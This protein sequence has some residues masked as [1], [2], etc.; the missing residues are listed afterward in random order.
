MESN[1]Q[2]VRSDVSSTAS[3]SS[4][5][6]SWLQSLRSHMESLDSPLVPPPSVDSGE[7][8][9]CLDGLYTA[10]S[11]LESQIASSSQRASDAAQSF[12]AFQSSLRQA[13][14]PLA[15][16]FD[17]SAACVDQLRSLLQ[18]L[19]QQATACESL[20]IELQAREQAVQEKQQMLQKERE[21]NA[22]SLE[23]A[24]RRCEA[25]KSEVRDLLRK[26]Q[27][28]EE[29]IEAM[30]DERTQWEER[31]K[32]LEEQLAEEKKKAENAEIL[33]T[34]LREKIT[35]LENETESMAIQIATY[36]GENDELLTDRLQWKKEKGQM[37]QLQ[38]LLNAK[39]Q[40]KN[41][42]RETLEELTAQHSQLEE[43]LRH[44]SI[45]YK[46]AQEDLDYAQLC[47]KNLQ[48]SLAVYT[49][50]NQV[51]ALETKD[52]TPTENNEKEKGEGEEPSEPSEPSSDLLSDNNAAQK[53]ADPKSP[54]EPCKE[55]ATNKLLVESLQGRIATMDAELMKLRRRI[56]EEVS[57]EGNV[58]G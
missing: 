28:D 33:N 3:V 55:C 32:R 29:R 10:Q 43:E 30:Q 56:M 15:L 21:R 19:Q 7:L 41:A 20:R 11:S 13:L 8:Y 37:D 52:E 39:E 18:S 35:S 48:A 49:R 14:E 38:A 34:Q 53:E 27:Q 47:V 25:L 50:Q 31:V 51:P 5:A 40:E 57:L 4:D 26:E 46:N 6:L 58:D 45:E 54:I 16:S 22:L 9:V 2:Q 24:E 36:K 12:A 23:N 17:G 1:L 42:L 44:V